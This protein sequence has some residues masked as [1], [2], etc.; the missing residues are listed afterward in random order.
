MTA[1]VRVGE[2]R[3]SQLLHTFGVGSVVDLP[4]ISALVQ[5]LDEWDPSEAVTVTEPRLLAEVR[6]HLGGQVDALRL[7]PHTEEETG[8]FDQDASVGV[9]VAPFP[10]WLRC[11]RCAFLGPVGTGLFTLKPEP[12]RPDRVRYEHPCTTHGKS[13]TALPV[14]FL[15]ACR[16]NHLDDFP[17]ELYV[18]R[19]EVCD[20]PLLELRESG[21][22]G[23]AREVFARCRR[24]DTGRRMLEAFGQPGETTMPGCRGRHPHLATFEPCDQRLRAILLGAS[25]LWFADAISVL[26]VPEFEA[27]L[28]Q[29]VADLWGLLD[30]VT[31]AEI[32]AYARKTLPQL[33]ALAG[34][35]DTEILE[36]IEAHRRRGERSPEAGNVRADEWAALADPANAP[37][38]DD[39]R[40]RTP[41]QAELDRERLAEVVLAE[42]LREVV[43][44]IG[45]TRLDS[46]G[47]RQV[48]DE[49]VPLRAPLTRQPP[50]WVPCAE[51]RG[52]GIFVR[53]SED[54]V[55]T[56]E[57]R[58]EGSDHV[59]AL[60]KGH[61][62]WRQRR[63]LPPGQGFPGV[64]LVLVHTFAHALIRQLAL[65]AG[66]GA[67]SL[68]ERLYAASGPEPMAGV[69]IYTSA[70]D[71][72]GTLGGLVRL[73]ESPAFNRLLSGA[74]DAAGLCTADPMCAEHDPAGD[75]STH[76][77]ACHACLFAAETSC[78]AGNRYLDRA[79]L[80][81]TFT[82]DGLAF[83]S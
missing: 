35:T 4:N 72:E 17:W 55:R 61:G 3:P 79:L 19:G 70:T 20:E 52:E 29:K 34:N 83:F 16:N 81:D 14:R 18:H 60:V 59:E 40:L 5:G 69:L 68:R 77:A 28:A 10:R 11:P 31:S 26:H 46:P 53:L 32:L 74:L 58:V 12:Y 25:N 73:G 36:A 76:G 65:E 33:R 56:W 48:E 41:A 44:L 37:T 57:E 13:P 71:S 9:P 75:Q 51:T 67:A 80:V 23:E 7:P 1:P 47:D 22:T 21:V 63:G 30:W 8:P 66:Y 39:F 54:A 42:R 2:L 24:C 43:A 78:E 38:S 62:R 50:R 64:R 15:A 27:P 45:F 82:T 6:A 49:D